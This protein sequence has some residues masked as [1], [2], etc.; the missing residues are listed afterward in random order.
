MELTSNSSTLNS[1]YITITLANDFYENIINAEVMNYVPPP[2]YIWLVIL[3]ITLIGLCG[4]YLYHRK[5]KKKLAKQQL[6]T[7]LI[8]DSGSDVHTSYV[9]SGNVSYT[10]IE[11]I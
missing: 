4:S 1:H 3:I 10:R 9:S 2:S 8:D 5:E 6:L 7:R 11:D